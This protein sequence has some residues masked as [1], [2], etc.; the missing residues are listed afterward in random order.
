M[1]ESIQLS[2]GSLGMAPL[3]SSPVRYA[4]FAG[5]AVALAG[6]IHLVLAPVQLESP[7]L[8][9]WLAIAFSAWYGGI[10]AGTIAT[11]LSTVVSSSFFFLD[12]AG[13]NGLG[14]VLSIGFFLVEGGCISWLIGTLRQGVKRHNLSAMRLSDL[15][16][17]LTESIHEVFWLASA[18]DNQ[19]LYVNPAYEQI[20]GRSC[21]E[22]YDFP[23]SFLDAIHPDDRDRVL[24]AKNH[25]AEGTYEQEYRIIRSDGAVRW[26]R[27]RAFPVQNSSGQ[28]YRI[29]AVTE[30]ISDRKRAETAL[31]QFEA[32]FTQLAEN[33]PGVI[34][35]YRQYPDEQQGGFTY[36]SPGCQNLYELDPEAVLAN[37]QLAWDTIHPD[38]LETFRRSFNRTAFTGEEWHWEWRIITPS[39][40]LK[41]VQGIAQ[42]QQQQDGTVLWDGL[43]L[44]ITERKKAEAALQQSERRFRR[45]VESNLLGVSIGN[46]N[47][48]FSY[49]NDALT[50]MTGYSREAFLSGQISWQ[51]LTPSEYLHLDQQA[52]QELM[53]H[54]VFTPFEKEYI[55]KDGSRVP[56][57]LGGAL[58]HDSDEL[59]Q[60][61][62][63]FYLDLTEKQ[64]VEREREQMLVEAQAARAEAESLNRVK[65]EFLAVLSHEL[66]TPLNPIL[67]WTQL[68]KRRKPD[69]ATLKQALDTIE[70]NAK[71]QTQLVEDLLDVSR[72]LRGK[73][74]L[75]VRPVKLSA[76]IDAAIDTINLAANAKSITIQ[77]DFVADSGLV[78]GDPNRLQQIVWNLLS[79]AVKF[80]APGGRVEVKLEHIEGG[81]R[82]AGGA[83]GDR[84]ESLTK[85]TFPLSSYAQ[86]TVRDTGQGI[87]PDFLPHVFDYFRQA[88]SAT[89]RTFGGLGLGLAIVRHLVELHGGTIQ[90]ESLGEGQGATFMVRLPLIPNS[91]DLK[92]VPTV[93][94]DAPSLTNLQILVVE[95]EA[96]TRDLLVIC[97]REWGAAVQAVSS[98]QEAIAAIRQTLPDLLISDIGMP[99]EDG[100]DL[101]RQVRALPPTAG[102]QLPAIALTAYARDSDRE[103]S[104]S[105]GFQK[106]VSKPVEPGE[107]AVVISNLLRGE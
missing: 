85:T 59:P 8:L 37:A 91:A 13:S 75:E 101:I 71:L 60:E 92:S 99:G 50:K 23:L 42:A 15:L 47:D 77:T 84:A 79:N 96:D 55:R 94:P 34:Y 86:I 58:L 88:D 57:L 2:Y 56:I 103:K 40:Q 18:K 19:I 98:A 76:V 14:T 78:S 1:H 45:L 33:L 41:W 62:V 11:A 25:E 22:L 54:R 66:R 93:V 7:F 16:R 12:N 73:L 24:A 43:L 3:S 38:D 26:V 48:R 69:E 80:T 21:D 28:V 81:G 102:G 63:C 39:H 30:D 70:R 104:L 5:L 17:Q 87:S 68:L 53:E 97:L 64:R 6:C 51:Q 52:T 44:D 20:W 106:H 95:D 83:R 4:T 29:A 82:K 67:G 107:L 105:A 49:V 74:S 9:F 10:F 31:Q 90:A 72:I 65:D 61:V 36:I 89:T 32:R 46:L 35:Q 27:S 100:Y